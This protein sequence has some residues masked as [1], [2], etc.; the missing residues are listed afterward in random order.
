MNENV[1]A[2]VFGQDVL[3]ASIS[4]DAPPLSFVA[5]AHARDGDLNFNPSDAAISYSL[6][7]SEGVGVFFIDQKGKYQR[8][9]NSSPPQV[10]VATTKSVNRNNQL[11]QPDYLIIQ[12]VPVF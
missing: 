4:E 8:I 7:G 11:F 10:V 12:V 6:I 2:P 3:E 1:H 5:S 9:L